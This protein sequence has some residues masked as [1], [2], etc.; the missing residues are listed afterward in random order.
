ML[1]SI[2]KAA[3]KS[4][5]NGWTA[6]LGERMKTHARL[7]AGPAQGRWTQKKEVTDR[8]R[9]E[10]KAMTI[11]ERESWTMLAKTLNKAQ[12]QQPLA[13]SSGRF[14][15]ASLFVLRQLQL[16][17]H[18]VAEMLGPAQTP[19]AGQVPA[20]TAAACK[21]QPQFDRAKPPASLT[22]AVLLGAREHGLCRT[23]ARD[24]FKER[25]CPLV[26]PGLFSTQCMCRSTQQSSTSGQDF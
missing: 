22:A 16:Q 7:H 26:V 19:T 14:P 15:V 20:G 13:C 3:P 25:M 24:T 8:I 10:W 17:M 9:Q 12:S 4:R 21:S 6:F 23:N 5:R 18:I 1:R 11:P 2:A